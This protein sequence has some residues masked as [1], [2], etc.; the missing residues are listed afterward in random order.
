MEGCKPISYLESFTLG[1]IA[2]DLRAKDVMQYGVISVERTAP[3]HRAV[4]LLL[5]KN[6]SGLAVTHEG[7]IDGIIA[8][9]DLL[10]L[11]NESDYLPGLVEDYMTPYVVSFQVEDR[12]ADICQCLID[13][14][15]RRV[16][17]LYQNSLAGMMTRSDLLTAFLKRCRQLVPEKCPSSDE[18][19][20]RAENVMTYGLHTLYPESSLLSAIETIVRHHIT[21]IPIVN[22]Q[23]DLVGIIT[24]KDLLLGISSPNVIEASVAD[25]MTRNVITFER[26]APL[27]DVCNCLIDHEFHRVPIVDQNKLVGL[28]SRSDILKARI[29]SFRI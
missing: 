25:F 17:I 23:W 8:D 9:K 22:R 1:D 14:Y 11:L 26:Q 24:E 20:L 18:K 19:V 12:L 13:N 6:I 7:R 10:I 2:Y 21:G 16:P 5:E 28:I 15:F 29:A 27:H 4:S 3:L